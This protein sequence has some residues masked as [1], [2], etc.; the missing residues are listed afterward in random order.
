MITNSPDDDDWRV[1]DD[2]A[3]SGEEM[4]DDVLG[5]SPSLSKPNVVLI[6]QSTGTANLVEW[7]KL[8]LKDTTEPVL[9]VS[10]VRRDDQFGVISEEIVVA[11]TQF[12]GLNCHNSFPDIAEL[13][14]H[15]GLTL[16]RSTERIGLVPAPANVARRL[17]IAG[18]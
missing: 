15:H 13:A 18:C 6:S 8:A 5:A 3:V 11:L 2:A 7:A 1:D 4:R 12:P 9:R 14:W 10:R 16:G 17:G